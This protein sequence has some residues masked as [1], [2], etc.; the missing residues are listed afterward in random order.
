M[1]LKR[2]EATDEET[3]AALAEAALGRDFVLSDPEPEANRY[4]VI[5]LAD[6]DAPAHGFAPLDWHDDPEMLICEVLALHQ[7]PAALADRV[8]EAIRTAPSRPVG[9]PLADLIAGLEGALSFAPLAAVLRG[10]SIALVGPPGAGKTTLAAKLAARAKSGK[11][12]LLSTDT[13]R[14]G[15]LE[16]LTEYAEVLGTGLQARADADALAQALRGRRTRII[17]DTSGINPFDDGAMHH[18]A[19]LVGA[20]R[21]EP[22][23][24]LPANIAPAE[25]VAVAGAFRALPIRRLLVT[26]LDM[27][28]RLGGVMAAA[29]HGGYDLVG[30]SVTPHFAYGLRPLTP[31]VL[32]RRLL[33]AALDERRWRTA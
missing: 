22:V 23:L 16:Q 1:R 2:I 9:D 27:V 18:L 7:V 25:A 15:A 12:V 30:A 19:S 6:D 14:T 8:L 5:A 24:V 21:A 13:H 32:A 33:S 3:A 28:R 17:V 20:A 4:S 10:R 11:P 26:R 31:A 29:A